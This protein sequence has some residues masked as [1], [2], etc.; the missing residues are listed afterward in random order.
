M[1]RGE[2]ETDTFPEEPADV[3]PGVRCS[4]TPW[5]VAGIVAGVVVLSGAALLA[6]LLWVLGSLEAPAQPGPVAG[7]PAGVN[8]QQ[9]VWINQP[10]PPPA[11]IEPP[12][13]KR[14]PQVPL[15]RS[16]RVSQRCVW[17]A[18]LSKDGNT[19]LTGDGYF[20]PPG[21]VKL[22]KT[23]TGEPLDTLLSP[24]SD[25]LGAAFSPDD[26]LVAS[27]CGSQGLQLFDLQKKQVVTNLRHPSSVRAVAFA[28]DGKL[29]AS[30]CERAVKVWDVRSAKEL[31][32]ANLGEDL[33]KWRIATRLAFAPDRKALAVGSGG[34]EMHI[35]DA[36]TGQLTGTCAGHRGL[37]LSTAYSPDGKFLASGSMDHTVKIWDPSTCRELSNLTDHTDWVFCVAFAPDGKTLASAGREGTV[38]L[39]DVTTTQKLAS[40][41]A[42][43]R[44]ANCVTFSPDGKTL[45][46]SGLDGTV[47]LWDVTKV[48]NR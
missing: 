29:L 3:P 4:S 30:S 16:L 17:S 36:L 39:W 2:Q 26:N 48:V 37:V 43:D 42:H 19:L 8:V 12:L 21:H 15:I 32:S 34:N 18:A 13:A 46:S 1:I 11:P 47:K 38:I 25:V 40:F 10:L 7:N 14:D 45:V 28:R 24:E 5:I 41:S 6:S 20:G 23:A 44:E 22:W 31:W 33:R 9:P 27:A 35:H